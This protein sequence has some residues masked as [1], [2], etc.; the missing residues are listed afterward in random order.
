MFIK[1]VSAFEGQDWWADAAQPFPHKH[2]VQPTVTKQKCYNVIDVARILGPAM[3]LRDPATR[4]VPKGALPRS[5]VERARQFQGVAEDSP[6]PEHGEKP[7]KNGACKGCQTAIK[8]SEFASFGCTYSK[9]T[10]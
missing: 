6:C 5:A 3:V 8:G 2:V 9:R 7:P 10:S 4:T 1:E